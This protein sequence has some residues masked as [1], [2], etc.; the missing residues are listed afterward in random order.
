MNEQLEALADR[1][2]D[3]I[4]DVMAKKIGA[5][6]KT[7]QDLEA[8]LA[9]VTPQ[10]MI[11]A[12]QIDEMVQRAVAAI[13]RPKDGENGADGKD[14]DAVDMGEV[15]S[16]VEASVA[17]KFA[18]IPLP[19]DGQDGVDGKNGE[20]V[21]AAAVADM[22]CTEVKSMVAKAVA[23]LPPAKDGFNG[24]D[25]QDGQPGPPGRDAAQLDILP[26]I[27]PGKSYARGTWA[28]WHGGLIYSF[29]NT[30]PIKGGESI[31]PSGWEIMV[32][33][34]ASTDSYVINERELVVRSVMTSGIVSESKTLL[35]IMIYRGTFQKES[36]YVHGDVA[37]WDGS[38]WHCERPSNGV[39]P[40]NG[41]DWKLM[42]KRGA[43]GKD[44]VSVKGEPGSPGRNG[45]DLTQMTPEGQKY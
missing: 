22:V 38:T 31:E 10:Q 25:G 6:T 37:T 43:A 34:V 40:G 3:A 33:G 17:A 4:G 41:V 24:Q 44:G 32:D 11:D 9:A 13:P 30:D 5:L 45:K 15:A 2:I 21:D 8:K 14:A 29:R 39:V 7:V 28:K 1:V 35:P 36:D 26:Q 18:A 16:L 23:E 19:K 12:T 20:S 42:V 27:D